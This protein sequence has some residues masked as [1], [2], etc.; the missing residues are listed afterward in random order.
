MRLLIWIQ[1]EKKFDMPI[2]M[3]EWMIE[4]VFIYYIL[5]II[6]LFIIIS[7]AYITNQ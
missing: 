4:K 1:T 5:F 3:N 6:Y 7:R 2:S